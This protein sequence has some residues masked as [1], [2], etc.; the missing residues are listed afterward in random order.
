[1]NCSTPFC[2]EAASAGFTPSAAGAEA[3]AAPK[4]KPATNTRLNWKDFNI[5]PTSSAQGVPA[6]RKL[7]I[8]LIFRFL[9]ISLTTPSSPRSWGIFPELV[10]RD[11][12]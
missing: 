11:V 2:N 1:L 7:A 5:R 8:T 10:R 6:R 4:A 9:R 3:T 12:A